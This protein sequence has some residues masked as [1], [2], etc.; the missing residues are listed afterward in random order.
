MTQMILKDKVDVQDPVLLLTTVGQEIAD[1]YAQMGKDVLALGIN[2]ISAKE[3]FTKRQLDK[4]RK[5][6]GVGD[7]FVSAMMAYQENYARQKAEAKIALKRSKE[8]YKRLKGVVPLLK[9]EFQDGFD[10]LE[11]ILNFFGKDCVEEIFEQAV[12]TGALFREQNQAIVDDINLSGWLRRG[13]LDF[14]KVKGTL[15]EYNKVTLNAWIEMGEWRSKLTSVVY[16]KKLPELLRQ[17]GI[18]V[19]LIPYLSKT[20]YGAVKWIE[21]HPVVMISDRCQD[22]ASCWFTL[23]HE[24]GHVMLHEDVR[25]SVDGMINE[26]KANKD[27]REREANKFANKYLFNGG[28]LRK[29]IFELKREGTYETVKQISDRFQVAEM[30]VGYWM[31][32]AQYYPSAY[33]HHSITFAY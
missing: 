32:K 21:N 1:L 28:E 16:F 3:K 17:Y 11:D 14:E 29:Y 30:F 9:N 18:V 13:E 12:E 25:T 33:P 2:N 8:N 10:R 31:H 15:P 23:F 26:L 22:L 6:L 7:S 27:N 19:T 5:Q 24:F 20:V 4:A